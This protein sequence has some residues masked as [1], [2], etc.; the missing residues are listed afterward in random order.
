MVANELALTLLN[1][2]LTPLN[3]VEKFCV[4]ANGLGHVYD[5]NIICTYYNIS[6]HIGT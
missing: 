5:I 6:I 3:L 4:V 1:L 2:A